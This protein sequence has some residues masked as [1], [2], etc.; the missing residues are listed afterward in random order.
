MR[1]NDSIHDQISQ[2]TLSVGFESNIFDV[3]QRKLELLWLDLKKFYVIRY[4][5]DFDIGKNEQIKWFLIAVPE[6]VIEFINHDDTLVII[7]F[8]IDYSMPTLFNVRLNSL[9]ISLFV[10]PLILNPS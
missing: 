3:R 2:L 4:P 6:Q 8:Y 1:P 10:R 5:D 7:I 9:F